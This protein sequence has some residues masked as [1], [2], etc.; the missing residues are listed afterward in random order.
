MTTQDDPMFLAARRVTRSLQAFNTARGVKR[1]AEA[2][3]QLAKHAAA[4]INQK[5]TTWTAANF[6]LRNA[7]DELH[8]Q[9]KLAGALAALLDDMPTSNGATLSALK[10][11]TG[12]LSD[13][14]TLGHRMAPQSIPHRLVLS[15]LGAAAVA[16]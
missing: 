12:W 14:R 4:F 5:P 15:V 9:P 2:Q 6:K 13:L 10:A 1:R 16:K 7:V 8:A 11:E 3:Q